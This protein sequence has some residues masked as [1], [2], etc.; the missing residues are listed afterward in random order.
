MDQPSNSHDACARSP[1]RRVYELLVIALLMLAGGG[2]LG[3][4]AGIWY[5]N[6]DAG[7][8]IQQIRDS[9]REASEARAAQLSMCLSKQDT[10]IDQS[11]Q[12][13][14][15]SQQAAETSKQTLDAVKSAECKP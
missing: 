5:V 15:A 13:A 2:G 9:Y 8:T 7:R 12:A 10:V 1:R 11:T 3:F 14:Q 6:D 4:A